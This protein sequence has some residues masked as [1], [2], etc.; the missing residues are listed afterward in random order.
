MKTVEVPEYVLKS[1]EN[2]LR[3]WANIN[4]SYK[5]ESCLDRDTIGDMNCIRKL[6]S[7]EELTGMERLEEYKYE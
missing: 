5:K 7:G 1:I 2:T 3:R 4:N 6:L